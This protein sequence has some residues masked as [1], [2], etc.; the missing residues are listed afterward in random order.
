MA[1]KQK[2]DYMRTNPDLSQTVLPT[3]TRTETHAVS[4]CV[5]VNMPLLPVTII[6]H[7]TLGYT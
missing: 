4:V 6:T 1:W 5:R 2:A 3:H 7:A